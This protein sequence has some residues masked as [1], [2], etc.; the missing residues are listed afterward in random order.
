[1][2]GPAQ[3]RLQRYLAACGVCSR[4]AAEKLIS[5]G[6]VSVN[7]KVVEELG[8]RVTPGV[9]VVA[10]DGRPVLL[11]EKVIYLFHKPTN[12]ITTMDDPQGRPCVGDV[13][14]TLPQR[15]FPVGR[16]DSDVSG[17][18]LLT[19]D[20]EYADRL[21]HPRHEVERLYIAVVRGDVTQRTIDRLLT[22]IELE[23]GMGKAARLR[24]LEPSKQLNE[25]FDGIP[26][27]CSILEL[28]VREGRKHFVKRLLAASGHGVEK[29]SRI[30]F[31][32]YE[33]GGLPLEEIRQSS[34]RSL[35]EK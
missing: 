27:S 31:G 23:D 22:G 3:Q 18:L 24:R 17:L 32:P 34:F 5:A 28:G 6:R 2:D 29:L 8:T 30:A 35:E 25:R 12:L 10:V 21:L 33:L 13:L 19:N 15:V 9:D 7:Q 14:Q 4:R 20:G 1:M 26:Q 11:E 16:L